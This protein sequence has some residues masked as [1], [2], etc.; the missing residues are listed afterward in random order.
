MPCYNDG[1]YIQEAINSAL[2]QTYLNLEVIVV[3]D[4]SDDRVTQDILSG[5]N[6]E[7]IR[8]FHTERKGP[9]AARNYGIENARGSFI[10]PLDADDCIEPTYVEK[11]VHI[12]VHNKEIG[13]VYC[14]ADLFGEESGRWQLPDYSFDRMLLDNI[15]FVSAMFYKTDWVRVGGY[16]TTLKNGME[17]Y[18]FWLSILELGKEIH[19]ISEVLFH[20][21]IK[22][23]S[24]T[25]AFQYD[26]S[27][28]QETYKLLYDQ[29]K[30][31]YTLHQEQYAKVLR[32][33]LIEHIFIKRTLEQALEVY[34]EIQNIPIVKFIIR[35]FILKK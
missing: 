2:S 19:Q 29:H 33:A 4:G 22:K 28:V 25:T 9:S 30:E 17:D 21:R 12:L 18:D 3:D 8:L 6:D 35:R 13:V 15:V 16:K 32:E 24:R 23:K 5:I 26:I 14:Q 7:R 34:T 27:N 10:L 31:F 1:A 20:Y 11:A